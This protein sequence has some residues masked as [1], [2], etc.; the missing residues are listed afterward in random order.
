M[1]EL[2][3]GNGKRE[4]TVGSKKRLPEE[5]LFQIRQITIKQIEARVKF[6]KSKF[7]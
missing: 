7:K 1:T 2:G 5:K 3:N 6:N 4:S